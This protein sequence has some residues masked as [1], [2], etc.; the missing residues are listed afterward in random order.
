MWCR[1]P[2]ALN[3]LVGRILDAAVGVRFPVSAYDTWLPSFLSHSSTKL[4]GG[5]KN[6]KGKWTWCAVHL[7]IH[8]GGNS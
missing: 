2:A 7:S 3:M 4:Q 1:G 5:G 6:E 8:G